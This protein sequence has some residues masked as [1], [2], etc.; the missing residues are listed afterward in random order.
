MK[1]FRNRMMLLLCA[2]MLGMVSCTNGTPAE[3]SAAAE[4]IETVETAPV[5]T[6]VFLGTEY[7]LPEGWTANGRVKPYYN[8]SDHTLTLLCER[9]GET[10]LAVLEESGEVV[11]ETAVGLEEDVLLSLTGGL[12]TEEGLY[13]IRSQFNGQKQ[14][15]ETYAG[16]YRPDSGTV[17]VSEEISSMF[18]TAQGYFSVSGMA[19]DGDGGLYLIY[20]SEIVVL[21]EHLRFDFNIAADDWIEE[22]IPSPDGT[23]YAR[24]FRSLTEIDRAAKMFGDSRNL[25][26]GFDA[27]QYL[28]GE[29]YDLYYSG[30]AG[31]YGYDFSSGEKTLVMDYLN[32][33]LIADNLTIAA[34]PSPDCVLLYDGEVELPVT[35]HRTEDIDLSQTTIL[36]IAFVH[37][38]SGL[39]AAVVEF[40]RT[41]PDIR[42]VV[43]NYG[44][45]M[46]SEDPTGGERR[47][48][49]DLLNGLYQPDIV[50]GWGL[51]DQVLLEIYENGLYTDLYPLMEADEDSPVKKD[52]LLNSV[53]RMFESE[54]GELMGIAG[55]MRVTTVSAKTEIV[56]DNV[57]WTLPELLD[58]AESLPEGS[59]LLRELAQENAAQY[60]LGNGGYD[61]FVDF[62][63]GTCRFESED[64]LRY[65]EFLKTFP[66]TYSEA[67]AAFGTD[68]GILAQA[69]QEGTLVLNTEYFMNGDVVPTW[70][71]GYGR[72]GTDEIVRIGYA[73]PE[74]TV[75]NATIMLKPYVMTSY[76]DC[77]EEAWEFLSAVAEKEV[78]DP[79]KGIPVLRSVLKERCMSYDGFWFELYTDGSADQFSPK[80]KY[81]VGR[82]LPKPGI[83]VQFTE[84]TAEEIVGWFDDAIG[85]PVR[86]HADSEV[87]GIVN[88]EITAYL[89]GT[90]SAADCA[91]VI[92][93]RVSIWLAEHQ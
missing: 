61:T 18:T 70:M 34:V 1:N 78:R 7:S 58:V 8:P 77:P 79:L 31:L 80:M 27:K 71:T 9:K 11:R 5:L 53:R 15:A 90:K 68:R 89:A 59:R 60:L 13:Y 86:D 84:E 74:D 69:Y 93:S 36:E 12:I 28:F 40:N 54:N 43:R 67:L 29:G 25:P 64:F 20:N 52:D 10:V 42:A 65:L 63:T 24:D 72:F 88:E 51:Y 14:A 44:V 17:T 19:A 16:M 56:G 47:L 4:T 45:Y 32:S 39:N 82:T 66:A 73:S 49:N 3:P 21:D 37:E 22:L 46:T 35:Y 81:E 50:A 87:S 62:E 48:I 76:C 85:L 26:G 23:V 6:N 92:Q 38:D 91:R 75:G 2:A 33:S 41:H 30:T 83:A 55:S 57:C